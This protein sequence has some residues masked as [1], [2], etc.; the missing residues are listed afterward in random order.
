MYIFQSS[1]L[2]QELFIRANLPDDARPSNPFVARTQDQVLTEIT[3]AI[4]R[5]NNYCFVIL[6]ASIRREAIHRKSTFLIGRFYRS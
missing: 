3:F 5:V 1:F 6:C 2:F 4:E